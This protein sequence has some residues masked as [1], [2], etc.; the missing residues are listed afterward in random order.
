M[1]V[2]KVDGNLYSSSSKTGSQ[3]LSLN[4]KPHSISAEKA[5]LPDQIDDRITPRPAHQQALN[6]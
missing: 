5:R 1:Q 2:V 6:D 4:A 3:T